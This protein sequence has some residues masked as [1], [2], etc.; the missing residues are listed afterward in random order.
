ML[1]FT[2]RSR[3]VSPSS[4][5]QR[6][7][8]R[9]LFPQAVVFKASV[10]LARKARDLA[11]KRVEAE[12][13]KY[14]LGT[15]Q[16]FFVLTA[17]GDLSTAESALLTQMINHR[18]NQLALYRQPRSGSRRISPGNLGKRNAI[19]RVKLLTCAPKIFCTRPVRCER[20]PFF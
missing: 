18:L 19:W 7:E 17:Q 4:P 20:A 16:I 11:R 10:E 15:E 12:Q 2:A 5:P 8:R 9:P 6:L 3:F 13:K 14:E 1:L